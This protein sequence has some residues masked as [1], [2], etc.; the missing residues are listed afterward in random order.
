MAPY[1]WVL[2]LPFSATTIQGPNLWLAD[3][4]VASTSSI[5]SRELCL[6]FFITLFAIFFG[7]DEL[8]WPQVTHSKH[9]VGKLSY[10]TCW[11]LP[12]R[13]NWEHNG[14]SKAT[15]TAIQVNLA[16]L[17]VFSHY[18]CQNEVTTT[19][20]LNSAKHNPWSLSKH[21]LCIW[22]P[23]KPRQENNYSLDLS[24][25]NRETYTIKPPINCT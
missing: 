24:Q 2:W 14:L 9:M 5:R 20:P 15:S 21:M 19:V 3:C 11:I 4:T 16:L 18:H 22:I 12:S 7:Q 25:R 8:S 17:K 6:S 23:F 10:L 1:L 13:R